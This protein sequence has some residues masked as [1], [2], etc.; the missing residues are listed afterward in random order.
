MEPITITTAIIAAIAAG[1][2]AG[3]TEI[4]K[5]AV[6]D[7][8]N[9]LKALIARKFGSDSDLADAVAG[10]EKRPDSDSR[11]GALQEEVESAQAQNDEGIQQAVNK[12]MEAVRAQPGGDQLV[13]HTQTAIGNNIAQAAGGSTATVNVNQPDAQ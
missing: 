11:K 12:L 13:Q 1:A 4:S 8:Y 2:T 10:V 5:K 7:A 3:A 6:A 9:G